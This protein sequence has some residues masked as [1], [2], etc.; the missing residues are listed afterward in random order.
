LVHNPYIYAEMR[1]LRTSSYGLQVLLLLTAALSSSRA[2]A[3]STTTDQ[4][5]WL[6]LNASGSFKKGW[7][8]TTQARIR[9]TENISTYKGAYF[10]FTGEKKFNK[11]NSAE[12]NYRLAVINEDGITR[13]YHRYALAYERVFRT[14]A[15]KMYLRPMVQYQQQ[16][17]LAD[18][19][20]SYKSKAYF[21]PR[22]T[23]KR[24]L[25]EK[26]DLYVYGEPFFR[27]KSGLNIDWWQNSLGLKYQVKKDLK[28]N[29]YIIWQP[30]FSRKSFRTNFI[31]GIDV[32]FKLGKLISKDD[33]PS[34]VN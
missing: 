5:L 26:W 8:F 23:V 31:Y 33:N 2:G 4:Q 14:T 3:Q 30:D 7:S 28:L 12:A 25:S 20:V 22:F 27:L 29:P 11:N 13:N 1:Q 6:G 32:E 10:Y 17:T 16:A 21:R 9:Y 18:V 19:E 34:S 15:L 24:S